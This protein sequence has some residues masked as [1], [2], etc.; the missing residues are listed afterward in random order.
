MSNYSWTE[1]G[2]YLLIEGPEKTIWRHSRQAP[3]YLYDVKTK[4]IKALGDNDPGLRNVK[5][6]PDG[7]KVGFV[8]DHNIYI[9]DLKYRRRRQL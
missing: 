8:R 2:N 7:K 9:A 1:D 6:S 4:E 5:L 3:Y